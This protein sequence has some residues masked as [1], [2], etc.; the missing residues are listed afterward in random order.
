MISNLNGDVK[1]GALDKLFPR[2]N[3][4]LESRTSGSFL[5]G[6]RKLPVSPLA[7]ERSTDVM[8]A[9]GVSRATFTLHKSGANPIFVFEEKALQVTHCQTHTEKLT[10]SIPLWATFTCG[11]EIQNVAV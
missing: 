6:V 4:E 11:T 7:P 8:F 1:V 10:C 2:R 5:P 3:H 9:S